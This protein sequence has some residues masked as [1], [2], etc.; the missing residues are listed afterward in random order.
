MTVTMDRCKA[1]GELPP[2]LSYAWDDVR[3]PEPVLPE[4]VNRLVKIAGWGLDGSRGEELRRC[5]VCGANFRWES[6]F[7]VLPPACDSHLV[8][9]RIDAAEAEALRTRLET[10]ARGH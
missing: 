2:R 6:H 8:L 4:A 3:D 1:C 7:D 10:L 9:E 5:P